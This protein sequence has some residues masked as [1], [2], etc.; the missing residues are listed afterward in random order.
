[1][2]VKELSDEE[3][4]KQLNKYQKEVAT[5][6][7][8]QY[9]AK[10]LLNAGYGALGNEHFLYFMVENAEA[11][12]TTGQIVN[13][14]TSERV[15]RMLQTMFN[16][17]DKL[18]I[19]GDTDS[20]FY[21]LK[22]LVDKYLNNK[23]IQEKVDFIDKFIKTT[24]DPYITKTT[25]EL[26]DYLNSY[27]NKMVWERENIAESMIGVSKKRYAMKVWDKEGVRYTNEP[28][29]K[30]MGLEAIKSSFPKWSRKYLKEC[31]KIALEKNEDKLHDL[32]SKIRK[33]F[34]TMDLNTVAIPSGVNGL[35][36]YYDEEND[37]KKGAQKHVKAALKYNKLVKSMGLNY[38][39]ITDG[40]K[41]RYVN[42]K[43]PNPIHSHEIAF[44]THIP[45]EFGVE[46][47]I[48]KDTTFEKSFLQPLRIFLDAIGWSDEPV[49]SLFS[50]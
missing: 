44:I 35:D 42:L 49:V 22:P 2:N 39:L 6:N 37:Y 4:K 7:S 33:E 15:E 23:P 41:I 45:P 31:Y 38:E 28:Y 1:M 27:E 20:S 19:Y 47:F 40:A 17:S 29:Y 34:Y 21:S 32:V 46:E 10:I 36:K 18:W 3:L 12:T 8:L 25:N 26:S 16:T 30:I 5:N 43:Y 50:F 11:I 9:G 24:I 13:R 14:W 48:E